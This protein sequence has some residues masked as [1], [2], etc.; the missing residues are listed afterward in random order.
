RKDTGL[1][2]VGGSVDADPENAVSINTKI[3]MFGSRPLLEDV[4]VSLKLDQSE[5]FRDVSLKRSRWDTLKR[6]LE[7]TPPEAPLPAQPSGSSQTIS[8]PSA[9]AQPEN[10]GSAIENPKLDR[11]VS[12]LEGG[13]KVEPI[14]DTQALKIS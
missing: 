2:T 12:I 3:L 8:A 10:T 5:R 9:K 14:K 7:D 6:I 13:I 4:I 11:F 1:S